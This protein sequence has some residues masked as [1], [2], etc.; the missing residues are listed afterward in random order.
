[1][2]NI[3]MQDGIMNGAECCIKCIQPQAHDSTFPAICVQFEDSHVGKLQRQKYSY[4]QNTQILQDWTPIFAQKRSF[5]I[6][7]VWV[8]C[9]QFPKHI[10]Y[11]LHIVQHLDKF[12]LT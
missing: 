12:T 5:L 2:S 8:T 3:A 4:L 10:P 7:D 9:V 6:K 11:M 1:M